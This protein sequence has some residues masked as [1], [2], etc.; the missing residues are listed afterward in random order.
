MTANIVLLGLFIALILAIVV[1]VLLLRSQR[2][3]QLPDKQPMPRTTPPTIDP[4]LHDDTLS[5]LPASGAE[6]AQVSI[7]AGAQPQTYVLQPGR[8][9]IVGRQSRHDISLRNHRVS[10]EHARLL[11][12]SGVVQLTDLGSTNGTFVKEDKRRLVPQEIELLAPGDVFWIGPD[13][14]FSVN[15]PPEPPLPKKQL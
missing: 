3:R 10:R 6:A 8:A 13:V 4:L 11:L 7:V 12:V 14:K 9:L 1:G 15:L 5:S 2:Q